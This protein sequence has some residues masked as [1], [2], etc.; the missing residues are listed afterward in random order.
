[1]RPTPMTVYDSVLCTFVQ[2]LH[3]AFNAVGPVVVSGVVVHP[4][5]GVLLGGERTVVLIVVSIPHRDVPAVWPVFIS[6]CQNVLLSSIQ[7]AYV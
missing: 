2:H 6:H 1:M 4:E 3:H 7:S 5:L